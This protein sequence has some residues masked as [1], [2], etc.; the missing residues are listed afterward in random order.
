MR[1]TLIMSLFVAAFAA[2]CY[3]EDPV[4]VDYSAGYAPGYA[5][6]PGLVEVSPGVQVIS[7]YDYPVFFSEGFYW[8]SYGGVWYRSPY[9]DRGWV[10]GGRVP[11]GIGRIGR[12]EMYAHYR[13]GG[14]RGGGFR[15][16]AYRPG[17]GYRGG[18]VRSAPHPVYRAPARGNI[19]AVHR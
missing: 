2:G 17:A 19:R 14:Y 5:G 16:P 9:Y 15:G 1:A 4:G 12:P 18:A 11:V 6:A 13:G 7:D 3:S 10:V 8:R